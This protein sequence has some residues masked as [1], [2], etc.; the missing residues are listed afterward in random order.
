MSWLCACLTVS[1]RTRITDILGNAAGL[2][3]TRAL[4]LA[5]SY[6]RLGVPKSNLTLFDHPELLDGWPSWDAGL[7]AELVKPAVKDHAV[8]HVSHLLSASDNRW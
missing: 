8:T 6:A 3:Y 2:G 1:C 4:E 5:S 7:I